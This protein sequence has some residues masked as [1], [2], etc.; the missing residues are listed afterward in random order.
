MRR[1]YFEFCARLLL[2]S[3]NDSGE[4]R[5]ERRYIAVGCQLRFFIRFSLSLSLSLFL[6]LSLSLSLSPLLIDH[7][8]VGN[9]EESK[10]VF[11]VRTERAARLY[12]PLRSRGPT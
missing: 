6:S 4:L 8:I 7:V 9:I 11:R 12:R 3:S 10:L 5:T 1:K 2:E